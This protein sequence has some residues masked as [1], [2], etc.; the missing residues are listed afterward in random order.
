MLETKIMLTLGVGKWEAGK[1][2]DSRFIFCFWLWMRM[3]WCVHFVKIH[4][5]IHLGFV[6][7]SQCTIQLKGLLREQKTRENKE[8]EITTTIYMTTISC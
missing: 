2:R 7:L 8:R 4:W 5:T 1:R 3:K 6:H